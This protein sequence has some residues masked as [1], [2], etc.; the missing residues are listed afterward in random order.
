MSRSHHGRQRHPSRW[1]ARTANKIDRAWTRQNIRAVAV[2]T[3][4]ELVED[5]LAD[6]LEE[7]GAL[8]Q[9]MRIRNKEEPWFTTRRRESWR[10]C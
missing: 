7:R 2:S 8:E 6:F 5:V 3:F 1:G 9:A 10:A 4:D